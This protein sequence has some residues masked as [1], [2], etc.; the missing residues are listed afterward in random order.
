MTDDDIRRKDAAES[1]PETDTWEEH[2]HPPGYEPDPHAEMLRSLPRLRHIETDLDHR[3]FVPPPPFVSRIGGVTQGC[4]GILLTIVSVMMVLVAVQYGYY[5]WGPGLLLAGGALLV[6]G[7]SGV[8]SGRK[9]PVVV[10]LVAILVVS[11]I[12]YFWLSFFGA[13]ALMFSTNVLGIVLALGPYIAGLAL[14]VTLLANVV[15]LF[16]WKRLKDMDSRGLV[17]WIMAGVTLV[18]LALGVHFGLQ[19]SRK[20]WLNEHLDTWKAEASADS[21]RMGSNTNVI[22]GYS[23]DTPEED[24]DPRL[25]VRLAEF[26]AALEAGASIIRLS[27]S[28]DMLLEAETPRMFPVDEDADD[29]EQQAQDVAARLERQREAE[30]VYVDHVLESGVDLLLSDSQLSYYTWFWSNDEDADEKFTWESFTDIQAWRV[31][32]YAELLQPAFYEIINEPETYGEFDGL[33]S[34]NDDEKLEQWLAQTERLIKIVKDVSPDTKIGVTFSL[35]QDFDLIYYE[36]VLDM[37]DIDFIGVRIFQ[38]AAFDRLEEIIDEYGHPADH[39][40]ELWILETWYG[41]CFAPQ[42]SMELDATWLELT[43]AFAASNNISTILA[44]DYGCFLQKG[45][46]WSRSVNDLDNRTDVWE[47][48]QQVIETWQRS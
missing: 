35:A 9:T 44:S 2:E 41:Y 10:S 22:L 14:F 15:A 12:A 39:G 20:D 18:V 19:R 17:I 33:A 34:D 38:P 26:D 13:A 37:D 48:W 23:F 28:G 30:Q 45:G 11:V 24:D 25:D 29:A 6:A 4:G 1:K 16:N 3:I 27:A 43:A 36:H 8:W 40:K 7:T 42:R 31:G 47:R 5:L 46:T 21:L 32:Y